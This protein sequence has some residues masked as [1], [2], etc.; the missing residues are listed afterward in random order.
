MIWA[1]NKDTSDFQIHTK[2]GFKSVTLKAD[3]DTDS[4]DQDDVNK[5]ATFIHGLMMW[6]SWVI[7]GFV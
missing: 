4:T 1:E 5:N 2:F 3:G 6:I 7:F